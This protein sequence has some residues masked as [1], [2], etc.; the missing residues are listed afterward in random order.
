M[1]FKMIPPITTQPFVVHKQM[2]RIAIAAAAVAGLIIVY[3]AAFAYKLD[4]VDRESA[5]KALVCLRWSMQHG[6]PHNNSHVRQTVARLLLT[7]FKPD[8][9]FQYV[10]KGKYTSIPDDTTTTLA[11]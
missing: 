10:T 2:S 7:P 1:S 9:W 11:T 6:F 8:G 4:D 5:R 3:A